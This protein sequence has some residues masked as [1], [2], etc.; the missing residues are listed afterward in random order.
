M[1][2]SAATRRKRARE[3]K[4]AGLCG[5]PKADGEPCTQESG[6]QTDHPGKGACRWHE[7]PKEAGG[8][9]STARKL[10][11]PLAVTPTQAITGVLHIAAGNLAY[12][13]RKV[14]E[15]DEDAV[16]T[17]SGAK[18]KWVRWQEQLLDRVSRYAA[19]AV[20]MGV[21]ERQVELATEQ[22][23]MMGD[24]LEAVLDDVGLSKAQRKKVG[25]AIRKNI[26]VIEGEA[27][28]VVDGSG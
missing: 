16:F 20:G 17:E 15:L 18:D 26:A 24:L 12:V 4:L 28:E 10:G 3:G 13:S 7:T 21:A 11:V 6:F 19:T 27:K 25:P 8:L 2:V 14:V 9:V 23:R 5:R 22:T 1:S